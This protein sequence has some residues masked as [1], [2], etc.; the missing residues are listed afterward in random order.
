MVPQ[1]YDPGCAEDRRQQREQ[2]GD[3]HD[4]HPNAP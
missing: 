2:W 4:V 1:Q 3:T